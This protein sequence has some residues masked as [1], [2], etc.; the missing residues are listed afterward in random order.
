MKK[1]L[2]YKKP[3]ALLVFILLNRYTVQ[4]QQWDWATATTRL[5]FATVYIAQVVTDA[6]GNSYVTGHFQDVVNFG[7]HQLTASQ[8]ST[9]YQANPDLFVAKLTA[10]G[11][12]DWAVQAGGADGQAKGIGL[13]VDASGQNI[14]V[15]GLAVGP[16]SFGAIALPAAAGA[17]N[18]FVA[19]LSSAG[20]WQWAV[21]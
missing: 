1:L 16:A 3:L 8:P 11:Q 14:Y 13:I 4:A 18:G 6:Q 21:R 2:C 10:G 7:T 17:N 20:Q 12:W 19:R 9:G 15:T 5:N